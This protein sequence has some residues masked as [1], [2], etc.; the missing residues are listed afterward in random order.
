MN[1]GSDY[2]HVLNIPRDATPDEI[3]DAYF[4]AARRMHPDANP[5]PAVR[6]DFLSVQIAYEVLSNPQRRAG[7]DAAL[8]VQLVKPALSVNAK[9]SRSVLPRIEEPHLAYA[10]V[11]LV[12]TAEPD[13]NNLPPMHICLVIDN[14]TSMQGD[15]MDMVKA[16]AAQLL[17]QLRPADI[18]SI[19]SFN[20]HAEI[21]VP[22]T[23]VKDLGKLEN[24]ISMLRTG[25]G[26]EI[27][28]GIEIGIN[29]LRSKLG[30]NSF[31]HLILLT[32]GHT[33]GDE[34]SCIELAQQ[35]AKDGIAISALGIGYE[36]NDAFLDQLSSIS[37]GNALYVSTPRD[38]N[39]YL[40]QKL[41]SL[42]MIYARNITYEFNCD[43]GI[44]L[45][46][47]FRIY[48]ETGP[49]TINSPICLGNIQYGKSLV[50]LFEFVVQP[51][52]HGV[53][54]VR[55]ADGRV[56]M[57]IPSE[58]ATFER[59]FLKLRRPVSDNP[60]IEL[61][62]APIVEAMSRLTLYRLQERAR[63]EVEAGSVQKATKHLQYLATHLLAQGDREL[64][65]TVLVEAEHIQQSRRFSKDGDK[66]IKYGTRGL[67]LPSGLEG[68]KS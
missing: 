6:E 54:Q 63:Q 53:D 49:L 59:L 45:R 29:Q 8:P 17:K 15:R 20:D 38:L 60:E 58:N 62:P 55:L 3:R 56:K 33:Y 18:I 48:P 32:D 50:V 65:H 5:D 41:S 2:Y 39:K 31:R 1:K 67:L 11:E 13:R 26:T 9:F 7:H 21:V 23:P 19:V 16:N 27:F 42:E 68:G 43:A 36:W 10:L 22:P 34:P 57:E 37:G 64:A 12:C 30:R 46:Y 47:A 61:P 66:R 28:K 35:A 4:D 40:E 52:S 51:I 25:G 14:S 24:T 44:E